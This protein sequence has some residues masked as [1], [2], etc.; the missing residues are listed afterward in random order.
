MVIDGGRPCGAVSYV[1]YPLLIVIHTTGMPQLKTGGEITYYL[2]NGGG[3]KFSSKKHTSTHKCPW[4]SRG[5]I[6]YLK[7][8]ISDIQS[9]IFTK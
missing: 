9:T 7:T 3:N 8:D 6:W 1:P 4:I 2:L 5:T